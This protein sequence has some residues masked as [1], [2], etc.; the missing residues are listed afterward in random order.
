MK[1]TEGKVVPFPGTWRPVY[2]PPKVPVFQ[3]SGPKSPVANQVNQAIQQMTDVS[4]T[5]NPDS[6]NIGQRK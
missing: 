6:H 3:T 5:G 1:A 4:R 2:T